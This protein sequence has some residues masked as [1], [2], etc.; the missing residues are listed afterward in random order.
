MGRNQPRVAGPFDWQGSIFSRKRTGL[1]LVEEDRLV[2]LSH[3]PSSGDTSY[4]GVVQLGDE[5]YVSYYT[6]DI[7]Q[8]YPWILGM[9]SPSSIRMAKIDLKSLEAMAEEVA[10]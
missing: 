6:N 8:D 9:V 3:L 7:E 4:S 10:R 1:Y 2:Y 5:L